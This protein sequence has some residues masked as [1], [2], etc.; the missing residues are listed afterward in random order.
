M[1][2]KVTHVQFFFSLKDFLE[3]KSLCSI[4]PLQFAVL[5]PIPCS[6][7]SER[8]LTVD[9]NRKKMQPKEVC[10]ATQFFFPFFIK[11]TEMRRKRKEE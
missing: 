10:R 1:Q 5:G 3:W 6:C 8:A 9:S 2:A 4:D 7:P 11:N